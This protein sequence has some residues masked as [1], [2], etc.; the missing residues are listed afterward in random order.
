MF[1]SHIRET[2]EAKSMMACDRSKKKLLTFLMCALE[3]NYYA[4]NDI[5]D[6]PCTRHLLSYF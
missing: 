2:E 4:T 1:S 5:Y 6:M 3:N